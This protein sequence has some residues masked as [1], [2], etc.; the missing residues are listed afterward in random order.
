MLRLKRSILTVTCITALFHT[1]AV[2]PQCAIGI[3]VSGNPFPDCSR[4]AIQQ[5][6]CP[7]TAKNLSLFLTS[8]L[9]IGAF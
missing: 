2:R 5:H 1:T 8:E 3:P 7:R 4:A 9:A 6:R